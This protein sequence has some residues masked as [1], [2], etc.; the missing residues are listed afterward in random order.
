MV[1][2]EAEGSCENRAIDGDR[3]LT[4]AS[5]QSPGPWS[6]LAG[7]GGASCSFREPELRGNPDMGSAGNESMS[8]GVTFLE[9]DSYGFRIIKCPGMWGLAA[10]L[11]GC[12]HLL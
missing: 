2:M 9:K 12:K 4:K 1:S 8:Q 6:F 10:W 3:R 11:G 5:P 7:R